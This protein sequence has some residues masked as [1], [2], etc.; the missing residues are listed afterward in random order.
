MTNKV[1]R[2]DFLKMTGLAGG[3][4]VLAVYLEGC[5]PA[6]E[7]PTVVPVTPESTA[8][9]RPPFEWTPNIYLRLRCRSW[10]GKAF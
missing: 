8:T 9:L 10:R 2:R 6:I 3:G 4:L 7:V 5:A 1:S